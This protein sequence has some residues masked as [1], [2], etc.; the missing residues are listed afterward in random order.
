MLN[1]LRDRCKKCMFAACEQCEINYKQIQSIAN[2]ISALNKYRNM[3]HKEYRHHM[4]HKEYLR[5]AEARANH[6]RMQVDALT[7][8][9]IG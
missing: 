4:D 9:Y 6:Y 5:R 8:K 7:E 2:V 1:E 3:Y